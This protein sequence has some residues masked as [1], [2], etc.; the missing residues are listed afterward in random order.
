MSSIKPWASDP[1]VT[2]ASYITSLETLRI[3]G[4]CLQPIM[5]GTTSRLLDALGVK[6]EERTWEFTKLGRGSTEN[7]KGVALF[8]GKRIEVKEEKRSQGG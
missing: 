4:I 7:V 2:Y 3:A 8:E 6:P 5:P 1:A